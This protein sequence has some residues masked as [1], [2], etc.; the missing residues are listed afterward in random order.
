MDP[1]DLRE[2]IDRCH[3]CIAETA[4][5]HN[6]YIA[7]TVGNTALI[8]FGYPQAHEDDAEGAARAGLDLIA[9]LKALK[10]PISLQTRI[11][12]ATGVVVVGDHIGSGGT[13]TP[14]IVG[15]THPAA[16]LRSIANPNVSSLPKTH[17]NF[18]AICRFARPRHA[19]PKG[20][21]KSM[22]VFAVLRPS[23]VEGRFEALHGTGLTE[24]VGREEERELLLRRWSRV[25]T[26][27]GQVGCIALWRGGYR[28]RI[29]ADGRTN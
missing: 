2:I 12:I 15:E 29:P 28:W 23:S 13:Q 25:K 21:A 7:N 19:E 5:R 24:L 14:S 10:S 11:G 9:T 20:V 4:H 26:G 17:V 6:G 27:E 18:S 16:R 8:C 22:R 3:D 1:E